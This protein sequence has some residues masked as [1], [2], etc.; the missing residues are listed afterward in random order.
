MLSG[1]SGCSGQVAH[2]TPEQRLCRTRIFTIPNRDAIVYKMHGDKSNL[3]KSIIIKDD[4]EKYYRYYAPF[5]TALCGELVSKTFLFLGFSFTDPNLDYILSRIRIEYG[6]GNT[7]QHYAILR[8]VNEID[9]SEKS[10]YEYDLK[11]QKL[12]FED[13]AKRYN[14]KPIIIKEYSD[15]TLILRTI[16]KKINI[17]NIFISGSAEEYQNWAPEDAKEFIHLLSKKIIEE[18]YNIVSGFGLG[19]G[20][21]VITGALEQIYLYDKKIDTKRLLLR[22]FPQ[23]INDENTRKML[24]TKYREDMIVHSGIV[25]FLYGNKRNENGNIVEAY[26]MK[27]EYQI[28]KKEKK[29]IIP[30]GFTGYVANEIWEEIKE[31]FK[32]FYDIEESK[33]ISIF[34]KLNEKSTPEEMSNIIIEFIRLLNIYIMN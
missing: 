26:G 3:S 22:P 24:W 21:Y 34:D 33:F 25:I 32:S 10:L 13:L 16:E 30:I 4:Y 31:D 20:S 23:G 14:I 12:F 15:I 18:G 6:E 9:Y 19:V 27:E 5:I 29:Y 11:K 2:A 1:G 8:E 17:K 28:A 7:K